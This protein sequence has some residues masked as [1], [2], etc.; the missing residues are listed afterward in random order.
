MLF[1]DFAPSAA[2]QLENAREQRHDT[3]MAVLVVGMAVALTPLFLISS[4]WLVHFL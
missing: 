4:Q 2:R 1:E 3:L